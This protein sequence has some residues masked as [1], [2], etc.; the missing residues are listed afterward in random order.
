MLIFIRAFYMNC[1]HSCVAVLKS[2]NAIPVKTFVAPCFSAWELTS[3]Y[4]HKLN[5]QV[6]SEFYWSYKCCCSKTASDDS[7]AEAVMV[8]IYL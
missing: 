8:Y 6:Y 4:H 7:W 3:L 5:I 2:E 1:I